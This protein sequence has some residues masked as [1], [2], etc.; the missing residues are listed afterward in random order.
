MYAF[1]RA[2]IRTVDTAVYLSQLYYTTRLL[3]VVPGFRS[4]LGN[5]FWVLTD[6]HDDDLA[7]ASSFLGF[8]RILTNGRLVFSADPLHGAMDGRIVLGGDP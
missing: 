7:P 2:T 1:I 6:V 3:P 4:R 5:F 8:R